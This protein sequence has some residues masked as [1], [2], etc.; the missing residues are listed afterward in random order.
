MSERSM[1]S[2]SID[3]SHSAVVPGSRVIRSSEVAFIGGRSPSAGRNL[4]SM[5]SHSEPSIE[6][7]MDGGIVRAVD[8]ACGCGKTIRLWFSYENPVAAGDAPE[9]A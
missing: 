4:E 7:V 6:M 9:S 5:A 1:I 2:H 3:P 8:V